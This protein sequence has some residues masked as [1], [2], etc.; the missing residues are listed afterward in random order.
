M[1]T[2]LKLVIS[3]RFAATLCLLVVGAFL[4]P[5]GYAQEPEED[6][7][8]GR[9]IALGYGADARGS[10]STNVA[11]GDSANA[12]GSSSGNVAIGSGADASGDGTNNVAIGSGASAADGGI[13]IG[14]GVEAGENEV[15]IG[16]A[17]DTVVLGGIDLGA[18]AAAAAQ[19]FAANA[20]QPYRAGAW[21]AGARQ[22]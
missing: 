6:D 1:K 5:S 3:A 17:G 15:V 16:S 8:F 21:G 7:N 12:R 4:I 19:A 22:Q 14:D 13:A 2:A 11:L 18:Q 9:N 20:A 10:G